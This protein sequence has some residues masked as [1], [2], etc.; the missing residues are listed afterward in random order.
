LECLCRHV[1]GRGVGARRRRRCLSGMFVGGDLDP[2][3]H[4]GLPRAHRSAMGGVRLWT[5][6]GG[7]G[8][9]NSLCDSEI[10]EYDCG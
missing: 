6:D 5:V 2:T 7:D 1:F 9:R 8:V 10:S 4:V 3:F